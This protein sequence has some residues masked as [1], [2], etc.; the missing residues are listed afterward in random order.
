MRKLNKDLRYL[1]A[2][3]GGPDSMA[4]LDMC[5]KQ[6]VYLEVAHMNYHHRD[7]ADRDEKIVRNYCRKNKIKFHK[8]DYNDDQRKGNFQNNA[9]N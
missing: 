6:D 7:T 9:R 8:A 1:I 4:L 5:L 2:V 3:S